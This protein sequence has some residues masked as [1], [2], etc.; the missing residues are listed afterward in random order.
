ML[1]I[2]F[3]KETEVRNFIEKISSLKLNHAENLINQLVSIEKYIMA[4]RIFALEFYAQ[5]GKKIIID[6][7]KECDRIS[8]V[9][10]WY[11]LKIK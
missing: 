3:Q 10:K 6:Y 5:G 8:D 1:S 9:K 2:L 7:I 11:I 4:D